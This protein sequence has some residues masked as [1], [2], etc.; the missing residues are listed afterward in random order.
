M[1]DPKQAKGLDSKSEDAL[2]N[3]YARDKGK[4]SSPNAIRRNVMLAAK[5]EELA[6]RTVMHQLKR[7]AAASKSLIATSAMVVLVAVIGLSQ[8]KLEQGGYNQ[9]QYTQVEIHSIAPVQDLASTN[10]R[11]K[12]DAA[13]KVF[14]QQQ[15]TLAAHHQSSAMLQVTSEGWT[16]ATCQNELVQISD[17]L[18]AI[19][20]ETQR[21]DLDLSAGDSVDILFAIDGRIIQ[22]LKSPKPLTC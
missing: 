4:Q 10:I 12:Y 8:Y 1:T 11:L 16:L 15:G 9:A 5:K 22:I 6:A 3:I 13:Y 2:G 19:L 21:I 7:W 18:L 20:N 17:E 14:L